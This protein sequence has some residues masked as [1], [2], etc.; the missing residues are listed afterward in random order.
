MADSAKGNESDNQFISI[1]DLLKLLNQPFDG[2]KNKLR[3]LIDNVD[4]AFKLVN[5]VQHSMLLKFIK[6]KIVGDAKVKLL[7]RK[8]TNSWEDVKEI[9]EENYSVRRTIDF[10]AC[11]FFNSRQG[12]MELVANWGSQVDMMITE[13]KEAALQVCITSQE[14]GAIALIQHLTRACFTQEKGVIL[15]GSVT[16]QKQGLDILIQGTRNTL[17]FKMAAGETQEKVTITEIMGTDIN[18]LDFK[19]AAGET[20]EKVTITEMMGTDIELES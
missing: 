1:T 19:M 16:K 4:T 8:G 13:L 9:L 18:T 11:K 17:D 15:L 7:V 2:H 10:Y 12:V 20:Q 14:Q 5:L 6:S 3:E